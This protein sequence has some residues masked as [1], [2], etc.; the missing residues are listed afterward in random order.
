MKVVLSYGFK[1]KSFKKWFLEICRFESY[2][3]HIF[4]VV[5][6]KR[7]VKFPLKKLYLW[8]S[9][10]FYFLNDGFWRW[11]YD[12]RTSLFLPCGVVSSN[13]LSLEAWKNALMSEQVCFPSGTSAGVT[14][15]PTKPNFWNRTFL[16]NQEQRARTNANKLKWSWWCQNC[17]TR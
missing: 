6:A 12:F 15:S 8:S 5:A 7:E 10:L 16:P 9:L 14:I 1:K 4:S 2:C 17:I 13:L 3:F 11:Y